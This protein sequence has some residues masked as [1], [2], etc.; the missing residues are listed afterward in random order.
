[1]D[2]CHRLSYIGSTKGINSHTWHAFAQLAVVPQK[3]YL[4]TRSWCSPH[5]LVYREWEEE[6]QPWIQYVSSTPAT[7]LDVINL[8]VPFVCMGWLLFALVSVACDCALHPRCVQYLFGC[9]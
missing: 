3:V 4:G 2:W 5:V 8:Q 7:R 1:M 6:G 9:T